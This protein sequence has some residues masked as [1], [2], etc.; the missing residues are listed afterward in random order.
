MMGDA[1]EPLPEVEVG[2]STRHGCVIPETIALLDDRLFVWDTAAE[3][4]STMA[5]DFATGSWTLIETLPLHGCESFPT[6]L[7]TESRLLVFD[8]CDSNAAVLDPATDRWTLVQPPGRVGNGDTVWTGT[9]V[10]M[11]G[12]S[13]CYGTNSPL[14]RVDAWRWRPEDTSVVHNQK[15]RV[16]RFELPDGWL[17]ASESLTPNLVDPREVLTAGTFPLT[18]GGGECAHVPENALE[19]LESDDVLVTLFER[20]VFDETFLS[21]RPRSSSHSQA[22][23]RLKPSSAWLRKKSAT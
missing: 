10:L 5:F 7:T 2:S 15:D 4:T 16:I 13:C 18:T 20:A 8:Y 6:P 22:S 9:E 17:L 19:V 12:D 21:V 14:S 11:W 3:E 23:L 1:W